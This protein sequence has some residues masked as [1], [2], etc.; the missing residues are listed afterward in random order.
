[1]KNTETRMINKTCFFTLC[2]VLKV[3]KSISKPVRFILYFNFFLTKYVFI[4]YVSNNMIHFIVLII[5][6]Y[7]Y[8]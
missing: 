6:I 2:F 4:F 5:Y 3:Y 1:M 7:I 8:L